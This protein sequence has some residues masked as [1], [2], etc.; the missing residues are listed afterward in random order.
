MARKVILAILAV[1]GLAF[2]LYKQ[3]AH[4]VHDLNLLKAEAF[5]KEF[6]SR[7]QV[8]AAR[9]AVEE[10]LASTGMSWVPAFSEF[11][12]VLRIHIEVVRGQSP[13]WYCGE[14][15]VGVIAFF[16]DDRLTKSEV[17]SWTS[18]CLDISPFL[19]SRFI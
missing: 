14:E 9:S 4:R 7:I 17:A 2:F 15:S 3:N 16:K 10:N 1:G 19:L 5:V 18:N 6:D 8:G 13:E 11:G 12:N